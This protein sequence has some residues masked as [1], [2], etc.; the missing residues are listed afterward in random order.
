[1]TQEGVATKRH[2]SHKVI[3]LCLLSLFVAN[4]ALFAGAIGAGVGNI[5]NVGNQG[6]GGT[7]ISGS[8]RSVFG[9]PRGIADPTLSINTSWDRVVDPLNST[10]VAGVSTV[11]IQSAVLQTRFQQQL[12]WGNSYSVSFNMQ[13]QLTTQTRILFNPA[14]TSYFSVDFYQPLMNGSGRA[15][16]KRFVSV[17]ENNR[18]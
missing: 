7:A 2:K 18:K 1:M 4:S 8:T 11:A 5:S 14:F 15:I 10:R 17:A 6:T 13:R 9:G 12:P 3:L 16:T